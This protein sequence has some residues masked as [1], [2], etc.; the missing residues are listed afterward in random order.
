MAELK[1][2][3]PNRTLMHIRANWP[4]FAFLYG[5]IVVALFFIGLSAYRG[6]YGF[7]PITTAVILILVYF[8]FMAFWST[9]KLYGP[10]GIR[11]Y[12]KLF[13]MGNIRSRSHFIYIG[14]GLRYQP[15]SLSRRLTTGKITIIDVYNPQWTTNRSLVRWRAQMPHPPN[16]PRVTWLDSNIH[17]LPVPDATVDTVMICQILSE[18]WQK[19][20]RITLLKEIHRILK[21]N[22]Q[23]LIAEQVRTQTNWL[24]LGPAAVQL[25]PTT[26]WIQLLKES[27][28]MVQKQQLIQG[29]V[30][31][32]QATK[33][34]SSEVRQLAFQLEY[35][36]L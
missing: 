3:A 23:L 5:A 7:V 30:Y 13:D 24:T 33:L 26:Y 6:W 1:R 17:L 29:L 16:D 15:V 19:G 14:L 18:F 31:C 2:N 27:G 11:P 34:T 32:A 20:D 22:G 25:S 10:R 36:P 35:Y 9:Q 4:R 12:H 28:F 8:L 21:P